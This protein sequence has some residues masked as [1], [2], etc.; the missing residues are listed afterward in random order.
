[1]PK[2]QKEVKALVGFLQFGKDHYRGLAEALKPWTDCLR[3][4]A[5]VVHTEETEQAFRRL[6]E[7]V[8][9]APPL[10]LF[11]PDATTVLG[12]DASNVAM[13]FVLKCIS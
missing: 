3:K 11:D 5:K 10:A 2:T 1:M 7:I 9:N 13:G 8:E 6:K 12:T 4:S